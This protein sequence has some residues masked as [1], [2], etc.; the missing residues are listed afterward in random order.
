MVV[1]ERDTLASY[2]PM[3][4]R[5][6]KCAGNDDQMCLVMTKPNLIII[7]AC[8]AEISLL[9]SISYLRTLFVNCE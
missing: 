4:V 5:Y 3:V 6:D 1:T 9:S 7:V 2:A 8:F